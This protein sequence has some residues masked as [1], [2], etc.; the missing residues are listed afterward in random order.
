L[1]QEKKPEESKYPWD[2]YKILA[3]IPGEQAFGP[4]DPA[5]PLVKN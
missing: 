5:C 1:V 3:H 4:L 2:Y